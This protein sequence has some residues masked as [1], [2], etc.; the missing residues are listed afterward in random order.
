[1]IKKPRLFL[2]YGLSF[3]YETQSNGSEARQVVTQ[4]TSHNDWWVPI[5]SDQTVVRSPDCSLEG[6]SN[7]AG[8]PELL[9]KI[10][11]IPKFSPSKPN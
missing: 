8:A 4:Y 3:F 5:P 7:P 10:E 9:D 6:G 1:M 2:L 11:M